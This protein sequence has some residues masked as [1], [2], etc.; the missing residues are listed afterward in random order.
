MEIAQI[1]SNAFG[2]FTSKYPNGLQR[3]KN[4]VTPENIGDIYNSD[5]ELGEIYNMAAG[6]I[7]EPN[8]II[9][10]HETDMDWFYQKG[11]NEGSDFVK[12]IIGDWDNAEEWGHVIDI[13]NV[14]GY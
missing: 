3:I 12:G 2:E 13:V 11:E 5:K 7:V 9:G 10:D 1:L 4:E 8:A 14:N 6:C